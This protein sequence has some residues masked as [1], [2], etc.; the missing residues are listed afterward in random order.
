MHYI[1]YDY[2]VYKQFLKKS[3]IS[4]FKLTFFIIYRIIK[5]FLKT[6]RLY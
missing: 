3:H 2:T 4:H 1:G 5:N 6:K